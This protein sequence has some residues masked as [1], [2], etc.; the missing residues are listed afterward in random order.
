[1]SPE[2][3]ITK[4]LPLL[5][6]SA[7]DPIRPTGGKAVWRVLVDVDVLSGVEVRDCEV[8]VTDVVRFDVDVE[9]RGFG[10]MK[11]AVVDVVARFSGPSLGSI[12]AP[13]V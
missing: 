4:L 11:A 5:T 6:S 7:A 1:M 9:V 3:S 12:P 8:D 10:E 2:E 13:S